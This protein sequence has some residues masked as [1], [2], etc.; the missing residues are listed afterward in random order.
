M[1]GMYFFIFARCE[2]LS[3]NPSVSLLKS[4]GVRFSFSK[5]QNFIGFMKYPT[6]K[7]H[8]KYTEANWK[9]T[10]SGQFYFNIG[11]LYYSYISE[12]YGCIWAQYDYWQLLS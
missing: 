2:P 6:F 9:W 1:W 12:T 11:I 8:K 4:T 10:G 3:K 5:I 7:L